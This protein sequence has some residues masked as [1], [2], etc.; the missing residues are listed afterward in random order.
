MRFGMLGCGVCSQT[1]SAM[2][3][4]PG[5]LAAVSKVGAAGLGERVW[6]AVTAWQEA[7]FSSA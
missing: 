7:Q 4:I 2:L 3:V 5:V 1:L 6:P